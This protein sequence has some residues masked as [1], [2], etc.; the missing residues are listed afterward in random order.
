MVEAPSSEDQE[1]WPGPRLGWQRH[2]ELGPKPEPAHQPG[3]QLCEMP[4]ARCQESENVSPHSP[5]ADLGGIRDAGLRSE[6]LPLV[7][8]LG[9]HWHERTLPQSIPH[10]PHKHQETGFAANSIYRGG[11]T[12]GAHPLPTEGPRPHRPPQP[13]SLR[14]L[15]SKFPG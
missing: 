2:G 12:G 15:G 5:H 14:H 4:P 13:T 6:L 9:I 8:A 3:V 7:K 11:V 10:F 1:G